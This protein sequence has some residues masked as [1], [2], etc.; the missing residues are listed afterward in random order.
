MPIIDDSS[1]NLEALAPLVLSADVSMLH[2]CRPTSTVCSHS[3][4]QHSQGIYHH[5]PTKSSDPTTGSKFLIGFQCNRRNFTNLLWS[6]FSFYHVNRISSWAPRS[7]KFLIRPLPL[8]S[9]SKSPDRSARATIAGE[10]GVWPKCSVS[11][12]VTSQSQNFQ[13]ATRKKRFGSV[14]R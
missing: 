5:I 12:S 4:C 1:G 11:Q 14:S 2:K 8:L 6:N 9:R 10:G 13:V 7:G 3:W